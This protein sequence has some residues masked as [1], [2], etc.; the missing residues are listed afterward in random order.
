MKCAQE[1][2]G[3]LR[4][5]FRN[6]WSNLIQSIFKFVFVCL[7]VWLF[8]K[9]RVS[10][11]YTLKKVGHNLVSEGLRPVASCFQAFNPSLNK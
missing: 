6:Y 7:F 11:T 2:W 1:P 3:I 9:V 4:P 10:R 8:I 5:H